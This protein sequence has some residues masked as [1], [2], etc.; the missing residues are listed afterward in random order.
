MAE[1]TVTSSYRYVTYTNLDPG[2][3]HFFVRASNIDNIWN[4][5]YTKVTV[6]IKSPLWKTWQAKLIYIL[7]A[8]GILAV[9]VIFIKRRIEEKNRYRI[10][11]LQREKSDAINQAKLRFFTNISHEFRTPITL[12]LSPVEKI[13]KEKNID[14]KIRSKLDL[15]L[16]NGRRLLRIVNQLLDLRKIDGEKMTLK[17]EKGDIVK[18]I[19]SLVYSFEE[20][21]MQ[22]KISLVFEC[23]FP[24]LQMWFDPDKTDKIFFN[25]LSNAFKFT[26]EGGQ[27][28]VKIS[29]KKSEE[30]ENPAS[31]IQIEINDTGKGIEK[32][33]MD[34]IFDRFYQVNENT[35]Y[36]QGSGLGLA[37]T[38][39][40][41]DIHHGKIFVDSIPCAG[42]S[43]KVLLPESDSVFSDEEKIMNA[44]PVYNQYIHPIP[45]IDTDSQSEANKAG[46]IFPDTILVVEDNYD[47]RNYLFEEL[48]DE[49]NLRV[50]SNGNDGL[51]VAVDELPDLIISDIM[52]P[53][54]NGFEL[55]KAI[56]SNIITSHIP[57][58]LL[59]AKTEN[60]QKIE[61]YS[62]GADAYITKPFD[63]D[64][65]KAQVK[66][67]IQNRKR[68]KEKFSSYVFSHDENENQHSYNDKFID[69]VTNHIMKNL[70]EQSLN[71]EHLSQDLGMSRGHLHRK[72][73]SAVGL[74]PN[75]YIRMI[76][77]KEAA[78]LMIK[79]NLN[80]S[81]ISLMVGF[82]NPAYFTKC[83]KDYYH[84]SPTEFISK[85]KRSG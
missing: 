21:A 45:L 68:L 2:V 77:L 35:T 29:R 53:E 19:K 78:K 3:Y 60:E 18:F 9:S 25:L 56:K 48:K 74:G 26:G 37:L 43:F 83:F 51:K 40:F 82:N 54:L 44:R 14:E 59:T 20:Y 11:K 52:M 76:R 57:V 30:N 22:K 62:Y 75:E 13:I 65:L 42:T 85:N 79:N 32:E 7:I 10:E 49:Y 16:K 15:V 27:V 73:K 17:V 58:L 4:D 41:V 28:T 64:S 67:I 47:L 80:I 50:V 46:K 71:V 55:C 38:K 23:P 8:S 70:E 34:K 84:L 1:K 72:I 63:I 31:Y 36:N 81:E 6:I 5:D 33:H 12:I 69:K 24:E 39:S 61:G 66:Q